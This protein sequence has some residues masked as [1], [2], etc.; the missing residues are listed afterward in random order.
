MTLII[1]AIILCVC[2]SVVVSHLL[3]NSGSWLAGKVT[4]VSRGIPRRR[5]RPLRLSSTQRS[6]Y[7][8]IPPT[9]QTQ[10]PFHTI[11][12]PQLPFA[13]AEGHST[14]A[15]IATLNCSCSAPVNLCRLGGA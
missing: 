2:T 4:A 6:S 9:P 5:L 8:C 12:V 10:S 7:R 13:S 11:N 3:R 14:G 1:P 15:F